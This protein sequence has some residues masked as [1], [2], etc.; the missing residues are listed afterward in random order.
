MGLG[1]K[2]WT[3]IISFNDTG[4]EKG[5]MSCSNGEYIYKSYDGGKTWSSMNSA[6]M[7]NWEGICCSVDGKKIVA[8]ASMDYIYTSIDEGKTWT[9]QMKSGIKRWKE[10]ACSEDG[11]ILHACAYNDYIYVS[12]DYGIT[13]TATLDGVGSLSSSMSSHVLSCGRK[14]ACNARGKST[15]LLTTSWAAATVTMSH[16]TSLP[17]RKSSSPC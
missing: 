12:D 17:P 11:S 9:T 5:L 4:V 3:E 13:W 14:C 10:I 6:G 1:P 8:C 2:K 16:P 7:K 15:C